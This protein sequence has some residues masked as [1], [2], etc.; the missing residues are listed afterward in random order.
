MKAERGVIF[1]Y[2]GAVVAVLLAALATHAIQRWL[3][4]GASLMF[5]PAVFLPAIYWGYGPALLATFL[6]TA[7]LAISFV[8][9]ENSFNIGI[10]DLIRLS[11][12]VAVAVATASVSA[13]RRRAEAALR[14]S[15]RAR[16]DQRVAGSCWQ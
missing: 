8:P 5:Y 13:A 16:Q 12:F 6:S 4:P 15:L 3:G 11:V 1:R 7:A 10:D 2:A 9:S 14:S